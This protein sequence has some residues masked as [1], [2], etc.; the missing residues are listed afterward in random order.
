MRIAHVLTDPHGGG[1]AHALTLAEASSA[2]GDDVLFV[3]P[4]PLGLGFP[5]VRIAFGTLPSLARE[6]RRA[7]VVHCHGV[8][9]R[10]LAL[11]LSRKPTVTTTHGL[12]AL[13]RASRPMLTVAR[14]LT[15]LAL[16]NSDAIVC[17]SGDDRRAVIELEASLADRAALIPNGVAP[18]DVPTSEERRAARVQL[19]LGAAPTL[20]FLGGLRRQKNPLLAVEA[21]TLARRRVGGLTLLVAGDGPL[22]EEVRAAAG[23]GVALLG[24]R[25]DPETLLAATDALINSSLWEGLSL[26]LLEALWRGRPLIVSDAPGN[27]EAAGDAGLVVRGDNPRD[28]A[29]AIVE[30]FTRPGLLTELGRK[31][32]ARA[33]ARFDERQMIR[34]T[35]ALYDKVASGQLE[36]EKLPERQV[37]GT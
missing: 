10:L 32:R 20:L 23:E 14:A 15:L 11:L 22:G 3:T 1:G 9:A 19:G 24:W 26:A 16:R 18:A 35:L 4:E 33:E 37:A 13:R 30:L 5:H 7:D 8:R 29:D 17:V 25:D 28:F 2:R 36:R 12:H 6:L 21:V 31:A 34:L 27:A